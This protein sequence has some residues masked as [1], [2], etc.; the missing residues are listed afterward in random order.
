MTRKDPVVV[1]TTHKFHLSG[2]GSSKRPTVGG[3]GTVRWNVT[4]S[5]FSSDKHASL[6]GSFTVSQGAA[7]RL[8]GRAYAPGPTRVSH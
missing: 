5:V 4:P 3:T 6:Y 2:P 8:W 1:A 7:T